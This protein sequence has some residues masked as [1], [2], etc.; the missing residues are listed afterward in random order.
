M[1]PRE[2]GITKPENVL[3]LLLALLLLV[4]LQ[5]LVLL[6]LGAGVE[7]DGR[8]LGLGPAEEGQQPG[9]ADEALDEDG[10]SDRE[11]GEADG[12]LVEEGKGR[13]QL[14]RR[15]SPDRRLRSSYFFFF[16]FFFFF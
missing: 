10:D 4:L 5:L 2:G 3:A 12:Q 15:E 9:P 1:V 6:E 8:A 13:E 14:G 11:D 16:F 7:A